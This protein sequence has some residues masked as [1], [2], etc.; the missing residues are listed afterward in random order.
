[1][2]T[3]LNAF[4]RVPSPW[5]ISI[6]IPRR[7]RGSRTPRGLTTP[8]ARNPLVSKRNPP[9]KQEFTPLLKSAMKNR[10]TSSIYDMEDGNANGGLFKKGIETPAVLKPGYKFDNSPAL[11]EA[12]VYDNSTSDVTET[13]GTPGP[14]PP[15]SSSFMSTPLA[16]NKDGNAMLDRGNMLTLREQEAVSRSLSRPFRS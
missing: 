6:P 1:M 16:V 9:G 5:R 13:N 10:I 12:S 7:M 15:A 8:K 11:P 3:T 14:P 4:D 2:T